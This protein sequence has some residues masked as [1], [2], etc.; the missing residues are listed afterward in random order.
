L[1]DSVELKAVSDELA[2]VAKRRDEIAGA[3]DQIALDRDRRALTRDVRASGRDR[4]S[5]LPAEEF[6]PGFADRYVSGTDRDFSAGDRAESIEDRA[7]SATA[8]DRAATDRAQAAATEEQCYNALETRDLIGQA[9]GK[10]MQRYDVGADDAFA[11]LVRLSQNG[12]QKLRDIA[13][14]I[15]E[16]GPIG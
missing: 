3:L 5:R 11:M 12:N 2:Q 15:A 8:R 13:R 16:A 1:R 10:V 7:R 14:R 6:D 4:A 9:K